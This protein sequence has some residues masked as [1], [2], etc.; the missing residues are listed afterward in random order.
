MDAINEVVHYINKMVTV[1]PRLHDTTGC[2][3][4]CKPVVQPV[5]QP[6]WQLAVYTIQ[7][8]VKQDSA[9]VHHASNT[10]QLIER[11]TLVFTFFELWPPVNPEVN[12][13]DL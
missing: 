12:S 3:T 8:V 7:P 5:W 10:V 2:Q 6:V 1:I 11:R 9:A 4:G 13:V